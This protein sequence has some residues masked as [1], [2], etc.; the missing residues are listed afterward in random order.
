MLTK[1]SLGALGGRRLP[2][3]IHAAGI[4]IAR[5]VVHRLSTR[6]IAAGLACHVQPLAELSLRPE[7]MDVRSSE[8]HVLPEGSGRHDEM[9]EAVG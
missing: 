1:H 6:Q 7:A 2:V 8:P 9:D 4:P 3:L 5:Q